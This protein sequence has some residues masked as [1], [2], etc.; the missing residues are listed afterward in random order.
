VGA[1]A[2]LYAGPRRPQVW[3]PLLERTEATV[4]AAVPTVF[5]QILKYVDVEDYRLPGLRHVLTAGEAL[6]PETYREWKRRMGVE[7][8]EALGMSEIS[9]YISFKPGMTV[10]PGACG[11]PQAGRDVRLLALDSTEPVARGE[12]GRI[13]VSRS[14]PGLMLDYWNRPE[15]REAVFEGEWFIGGDTAREDDDGVWWFDGRNDDVMSSFGYRVSPQEVESALSTHP[16]VAEC[17][18]AMMPT[19]ESGVE[20]ITA[21]IKL[22]DGITLDEESLETHCREHLAEYK[23]PKAYRLI[24]EIPRTANGKIARR[25]LRA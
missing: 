14:D 7:M 3:L 1:T 17:A 10:K 21:F 6:M 20:L 23:C 8:Y 15:E 18:V 24:H 16:D 11:V 22:K 12:T 5:R 13:A 25:E 9:T 2:I 19:G 4:F